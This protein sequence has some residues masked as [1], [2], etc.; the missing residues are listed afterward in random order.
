MHENTIDSRPVVILIEALNA[1]TVT[2]GEVTRFNPAM[3]TGCN[4]KVLQYRHACTTYW[5]QSTA[6]SKPQLLYDYQ[7]LFTARERLLSSIGLSVNHC[8]L[9]RL[10]QPGVNEKLERDRLD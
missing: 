5:C 3:C 2:F 6:G 8:K 1:A 4:T 9:H 7:F 10:V